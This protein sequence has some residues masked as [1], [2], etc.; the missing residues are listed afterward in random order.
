MRQAFF[1]LLVNCKSLL[2]VILC[3]TAGFLCWQLFGFQW[4]TYPLSSECWVN[5]VYGGL[6]GGLIGSLLDT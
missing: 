4:G 3:G 2:G 6:F 1:F 5:C